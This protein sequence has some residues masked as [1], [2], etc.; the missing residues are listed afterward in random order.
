MKYCR[1]CEDFEN[2]NDIEPYS[3]AFFCITGI[4]T[5]SPA[6][7]CTSCVNIL[8]NAYIFQKQALTTDA[9]LRELDVKPEI[10]IKEEPVTTDTAVAECWTKPIE[11]K[12]EKE[13]E[14]CPYCFEKFTSMSERSHHVKAHIDSNNGLECDFCHKKYKARTNLR[15]HILRV[16][17]RS[18]VC[19]VCGKKFVCPSGY[20][21][22]Q[23]IAHGKGEQVK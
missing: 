8:E 22:H 7:L 3:I 11:A 13:L 14:L 16:H 2:L 17:L 15:S 10:V 21:D 19:D 20:A 23:R 9:R 4:E 5:Y 6:S 1:V 18:F 12:P